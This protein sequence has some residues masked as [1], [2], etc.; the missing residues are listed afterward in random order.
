[1]RLLLVFGVF[2]EE[3]E[4]GNKGASS[5]RLSSASSRSMGETL[6]FLTY[7]FTASSSSSTV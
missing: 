6:M 7:S 4:Q 3:T 2:V 5:P 1:M